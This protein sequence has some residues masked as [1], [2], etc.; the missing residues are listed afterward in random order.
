MYVVR[1]GVPSLSVGKI[2]GSVP[3]QAIHRL[4]RAYRLKG[5]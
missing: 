4:Y 5:R 2:G 3:A 1:T